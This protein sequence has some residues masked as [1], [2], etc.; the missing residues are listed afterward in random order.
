MAFLYIS[1]YFY[2]NFKVHIGD[3]QVLSVIVLLNPTTS[4]SFPSPQFRSLMPAIVLCLNASVLI[5]DFFLLSVCIQG[6]QWWRCFHDF[7]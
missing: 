1:E 7:R 4:F 3:R 6:L 5:Y 2:S